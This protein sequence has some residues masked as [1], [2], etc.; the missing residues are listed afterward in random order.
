VNGFLRRLLPRPLKRRLR[1]WLIAAIGPQP[2][3]QDMVARNDAL[4][5]LL[6]QK[7]IRTDEA[8]RRLE[9]RVAALEAKRH[10]GDG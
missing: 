9:N 7:I 1:A 4:L 10:D 5:A 3:L 6:D 2:Q 8:L